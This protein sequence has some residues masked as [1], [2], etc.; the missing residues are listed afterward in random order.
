[1]E[2]VTHALGRQDLDPTAQL[3]VERERETLGSGPGASEQRDRQVDVDHL[4]KGVHAGVGAT[5]ADDH[6]LLGEMQRA[7]EGLT[8]D[9]HDRGGLWLV[10]EA[11]EGAPS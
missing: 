8:Q 4:A 9:A 5:R 1:V 7:R 10:R 2:V 6:W 3:L 11:R